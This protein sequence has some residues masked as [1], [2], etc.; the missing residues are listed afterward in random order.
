MGG[1]GKAGVAASA[2]SAAGDDDALIRAG[3]IVDALAAIFVVKNRAHGDLQRDVST[4]GAGLVGAF[5]VASAT[6]LVFMT[7]AESNKGVLACPGFHQHVAA[8]AAVAA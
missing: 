7:E 2:A 4:F 8:T 1:G 5:A 6:G 3:K